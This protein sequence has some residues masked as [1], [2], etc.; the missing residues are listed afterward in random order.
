VTDW[1]VVAPKL[2]RALEYAGGTHT[3]ADVLAA[4]ERGDMQLWPGRRSVIVTELVQ[5]PRLRA[6]RVFAGAG[7]LDELRGMETAVAEWARAQG[8]ERVEGFGR[9]GW[10]RA[11]RG[12]GYDETRVFA[13]RRL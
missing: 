8:C 4:V 10:G 2:E 1:T 6:A 12:M 11:L 3:L 7:D 13:W 5:Y 9:V